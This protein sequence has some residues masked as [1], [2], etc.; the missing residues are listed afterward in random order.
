MT[1]PEI[2]LTILG[3]VSLRP[4]MGDRPNRGLTVRMVRSL[5]LKR[6]RRGRSQNFHLV[7]I[8]RIGGGRGSGDGGR[9]AQ[10]QR[11]RWWRREE[12]GRRMC[13]ELLL[14]VPH[15]GGQGVGGQCSLVHQDCAEHLIQ[16]GLAIAGQRALRESCAAGRRPHRDGIDGRVLVE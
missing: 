12:S 1:E 2:Y 8:G 15:Q 7:H 16:T 13:V 9:R 4:I 11:W 6:R 14:V 10:I 3:R 5:L